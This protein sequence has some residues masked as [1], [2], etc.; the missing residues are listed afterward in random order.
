MIIYDQII[1]LIKEGCYIRKT[2][3]SN[4]EE[5][6]ELVKDKSVDRYSIYCELNKFDAIKFAK[7]T[8]TEIFC[9]GFK[10]FTDG[11]T[12]KHVKRG[13]VLITDLPENLPSMR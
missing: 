13:A 10:R 2:L 6:Y 7:T 4:G 1:K 9:D 12:P 8:N 3:Y 11:E 5:Q